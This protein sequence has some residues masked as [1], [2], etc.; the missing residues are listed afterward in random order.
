MELSPR[1][2]LQLEFSLQ[3]ALC[4]SHD[5]GWNI[6]VLNGKGRSE[7]IAYKHKS[8]NTKAHDYKG[9]NQGLN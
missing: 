9:W 6:S 4:L 2:L 5:A 1:V 3:H 8:I 7:E